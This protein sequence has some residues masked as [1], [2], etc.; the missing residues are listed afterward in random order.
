MAEL[1]ALEQALGNL[2]LDNQNLD[3]DGTTALGKLLEIAGVEDFRALTQNPDSERYAS[4]LMKT[5]SRAETEFNF[6]HSLTS[7]L[8]LLVYYSKDRLYRGMNWFDTDAQ[9]AGT[10]LG[11]ADADRALLMSQMDMDRNLKGRSTTDAIP[12]FRQNEWFSWKDEVQTALGSKQ[13]ATG[14][15]L[16]WII[17]EEKD[18][19]WN[20]ITDAVDSVERR[21]YQITIKNANGENTTWF[22]IDN[23]AV[24]SLLVGSCRG[25]NQAWAHIQLFM[26][27]QDGRAA[28]LALVGIYEGSGEIDR[29]ETAALRILENVNLCK[30]TGERIEGDFRRYVGRLVDQYAVLTQA[31][32]EVLQKDQVRR[33]LLGI[34]CHGNHAMQALIQAVRLNYGSNFVGAINYLSQEIAGQYA[35][36]ARAPRGGQGGQR[37]VSQSMTLRTS[38]T[39][40][41]DVNNVPNDVFHS[42]SHEARQELIN[43]RRDS[44]NGQGGRGNQSRGRGGGRGFHRGRG[45]GGGRNH[46]GRGRG[47]GRGR[48]HFQDAYRRNHNGNNRNNNGGGRGG[49]ERR[50]QNV[51]N[52]N[53]NNNNGN[54]H[55][56]DNNQG[57]NAAGQGNN[58]NRNNGGGNANRQGHGGAFGRG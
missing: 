38:G 37:R 14:A 2:G 8:A 53:N 48:G 17:R 22:E 7:K 49:G 42:L 27:R 51:N 23:R 32:R 16:R 19:T 31:G 4:D 26:P 25:D 57:N 28:W 34:D 54:N 35:T 40:I 44:R 39:F 43:R 41:P 46:G 56:G 15:S 12:P 29:R 30:F 58:N 6:E 20:P 21:I 5:I 52:N 24:W 3:A 9:G 10:L 33:L 1:Q 45:R 13:G 18:A 47:R 55:Q 36:A 11:F 50:I